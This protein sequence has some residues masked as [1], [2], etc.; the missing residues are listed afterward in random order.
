MG[1]NLKTIFSS[2]TLEISSQTSPETVSQIVQNRTHCL[3]SVSNVSF[4]ALP[5]EIL[6]LIL[7][8]LTVVELGRFGF[9]LC[10]SV[11]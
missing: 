2:Q 7:R 8:R 11:F 4:D 5:D 9:L 6:E 10:F 1:N 3:S